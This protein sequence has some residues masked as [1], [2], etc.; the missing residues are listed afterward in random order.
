MPTGLP[1]FSRPWPVPRGQGYFA[2]ILAV[3]F[4]GFVFL[5][6]PLGLGAIL[7]VAGLG[8]VAVILLALSLLYA[9]AVA[10]P[11]K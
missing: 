2:A 5:L 4:L 8:A 1:D 6:N 7:V 11:P 10:R 3:G 9:R